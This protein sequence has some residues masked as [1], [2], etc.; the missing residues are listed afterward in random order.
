MK[1]FESREGQIFL[2]KICEGNDGMDKKAFLYLLP[3]LDCQ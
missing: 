2:R 3:S 1:N